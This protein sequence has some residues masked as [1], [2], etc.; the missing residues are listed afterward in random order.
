MME[1][2]AVPLTMPTAPWCL[3]NMISAALPSPEASITGTNKTH[4]GAAAETQLLFPEL[5]SPSKE[6]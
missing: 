1:N 3:V 5:C 4:G 2:T 6:Y